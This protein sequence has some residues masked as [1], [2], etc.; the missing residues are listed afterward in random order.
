[1]EE[2]TNGRFTPLNSDNHK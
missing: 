1:M 2:Q